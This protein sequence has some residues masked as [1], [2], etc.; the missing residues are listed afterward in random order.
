MTNDES[1][2]KRIFANKLHREM[3]FLVFLAALVPMI[4]TALSVYFLI[5]NITAEEVGFPE[6][7]VYTLFPAAQ[8]VIT[9]LLTATPITIVAILILAYQMTHKIVGP[10]DRI[11][12][13]ID[14]CLDGKREGPISLRKKDKFWPLV[15]RINRLLTL[16]KGARSKNSQGS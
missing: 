14:E 5:F 16:T 7:I 12:R 15:K 11:V 13:E 9:V 8:K 2:G 4:I 1:R 3:F 10:F 6:A